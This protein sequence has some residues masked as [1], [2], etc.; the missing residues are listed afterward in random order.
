MIGKIEAFEMWVYRKTLKISYTEHR[1]NEYILQKMNTRR[2]LMNKIKQRKC[3]YFGHL[4]RGDGLQRLLLEEDET[5]GKEEEA[6][7]DLRGSV[8]S[9]KG[10]E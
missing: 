9:R 3:V 6:G 5:L 2:S 8:T 10:P 7:Q 4:I 1:T